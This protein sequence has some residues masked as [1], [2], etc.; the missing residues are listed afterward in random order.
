VRGR[1]HQGQRLEPASERPAENLVAK[2]AGP[3]A[4]EQVEYESTSSGKGLSS[5]GV[6]NTTNFKGFGPT[7]AFVGTDQPP[8]GPQESEILAKQEPISGAKVLSI[9]VLQAAVALPIHL[10]E[11]C[12]ATSGKGKTEL[13]R[14][15]LSDAQLQ[16][17]FAH[18]ITTWAQLVEKAN[19]FNEDKLVGTECK[20]STPIVRIVRKE[21]SGTTAIAKK[22]FFEI[23]K[24]AVD[25]TETWNELAEKNENLNWPAEG[26]DLVRVEKGSG[27][28]SEVATTPGTIGYANLN[29]VRANPAFTPAGGGGESSAI[30]W[31][32]LQNSG[33]KFEDP[34]TNKE[35]NEP[36][37]ANCEAED[38]VSLNGKGTK[39]KFPP[40]S[41]E[42]LWNEVTASTKQ[43][44]T[45]P[46]CGFT[47]DLSLTDFANFAGTSEAEVATVTNYLTFVLGE[48]QELLKNHD[49]LGL[50]TAKSAKGNVLEIARAGVKKIAF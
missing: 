37:N 34:A 46:L 30:F 25:G 39:G 20:S 12:T 45:Y 33:K 43:T 23:N 26:E 7:N 32:E 41:T 40:A 6:G 35:A 11:G 36:A 31:P 5:W 50:P 42:D 38:Y 16:G 28:A 4:T 2:C 29:E 22:F 13:H 48:G 21:G 47:Y 19:T 44:K 8:N 14:L 10:P 17:I 24:G 15:V 9:P 1:E 18:T 27:M 3:P 49:F